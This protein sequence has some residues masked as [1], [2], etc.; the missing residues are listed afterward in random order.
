MVHQSLDEKKIFDLLDYNTYAA[1]SRNPNLIEQQSSASDLVVIDEIQK[2][3]VLLDDVHRL[4]ESRNQK[5]LL[6]GSSARKLRR[7]AANL[8]VGR[9]WRADLFPLTSAEIENFDL[10][11]YLNTG[12]L[13]AI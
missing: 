1:L 5:F 11:T 3:P 12:G 10:I 6:T 9:A 13:P 8:L 4:I 7:G 2:L